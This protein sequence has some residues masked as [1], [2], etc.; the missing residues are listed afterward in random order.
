MRSCACNSN[1][2][3]N[4]PEV[5]Q[6]R[7]TVLAT[8]R[9]ASGWKSTALFF[10]V[11]LAAIFSIATAAD[12]KPPCMEPAYRAF[13]FWAG[14]WDV[15][16]VGGQSKIA[17]ARID[18][19]LDG[20]V[21]REDYEQFD[22]HHGQSYTIYDAGRQVWHQSWV[23]NR[24]EML[25]IEGTMQDG[26]IVLSGEDRHAGTLV[27]GIW[28]PEHGNVREIADTSADRGKTWKPWFDIIFRPAGDPV[29]DSSHSKDADAVKELDARY[30]Q[31]VKDNDAETMGVMLADDFMLVTGS[32]KS[33]SK[34]D[35]LEEARSGRIRYHRQDDSDQAVRIWGDTAVITAK[36]TAKGTD[37]GNPFE[38][39]VWF[40]DTYV[41]SATGWK[42]VF[43]QSST[44]V[45]Q[46]PH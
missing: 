41:K 15:Y 19:I 31:A 23:T 18:P 42:Y 8:N 10:L 1:D 2:A 34:A 27:R 3:N 14:Q 29:G 4:S 5:F 17:S 20:C 39:Q 33:Y 16:D 7:R 36:L 32:G 12:V 11:F 24:G 22:G 9:R 6:W 30:Q 40:S 13:D 45:P 28:K 46:I 38:Y 26:S 43:G 44:H 35:L 25:E 21:L 37:S